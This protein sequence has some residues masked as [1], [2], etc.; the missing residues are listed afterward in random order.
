MSKTWL[1]TG[2][3]RGLG[4]KIAEAALA[5][6]HKVLATARRPEQL[7]DLVKKYGDQI[8]AVALDVTDA[9]AAHAA[10]GVAVDA[11][12]GL[13]VLVNNAGYGNVASIEDIAMDDFRAQIETNFFGVV[14]VTRA[15]LPVMRKQKFG[16]ILQVSSIGG[17]LGAACLGAYQSAKWALEGF[18]EV[19]SKEVAPLGINVTIV[20]PGGF[21]TDWAGSSMTIADVSEPYRSTV[22]AHAEYSRTHTGTERGDPEKGAE[23]ILKIAEMENPP[24]RLLLGGDAV[25]L[26]KLISDARAAEDAKWKELSLSTDFLGS[27]DP[28]VVLAGLMK[29]K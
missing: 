29:T 10:V 15:A 27:P 19:L 22:G 25:F 13:D 5:A 24:L 4:R 11:F 20:E 9:K 14:N 21:R 28:A 2:S 6:G 18:S 7:S 17:R 3:S 12:G 16:R 23:V 26:A 8:R 1:V